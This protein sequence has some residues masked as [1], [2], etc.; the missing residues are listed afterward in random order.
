M[1]K[2]DSFPGCTSS[3]AQPIDG[4]PGWS[5]GAETELPNHVGRWR[6]LRFRPADAGREDMG[7]A[8]LAVGLREGVPTAF[9]PDV[10]FF[11]NV[12]PTSENWGCGYVVNGPFKLDPGRTHVSL[13][14]NT[15][16]RT[17][18]GLGEALG[19]GLI[20]LHNVLVDPTDAVT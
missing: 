3:T 15:T 4:A 2:A 8:A 17:V 12:T 6:I 13:D 11:W 1:W 16:L 9:G 19:R 7:T 14:D 20:E 5:V 10:P 18:G